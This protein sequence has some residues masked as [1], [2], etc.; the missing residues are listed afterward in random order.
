MSN[1][2]GIFNIIFLLFRLSFFNICDDT[3]NPERSEDELLL[4]IG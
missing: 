3:F 4:D 2:R 1:V